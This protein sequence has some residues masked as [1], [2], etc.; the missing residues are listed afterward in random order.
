MYTLFA[1]FLFANILDNMQAC[2]AENRLKFL[3]TLE[4]FFEEA[5]EQADP[6]AGIEEEYKVVNKATFQ[7]RALRLLASRSNHF[8]TPSMTPFKALPQY[9]SSVIEQLSK[10]FDKT[11]SDGVVTTTTVPADVKIKTEVVEP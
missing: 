11:S 3:P 1:C 2:K 7:W 9:L 6:D 4:N 8:F 5:V 10:E